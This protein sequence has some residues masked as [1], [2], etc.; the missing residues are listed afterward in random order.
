MIGTRITEIIQQNLH[1]MGKRVT[2]HI[3]S[4]FNNKIK[5]YLTIVK[6]IQWLI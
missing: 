6:I 3:K 2:S 1:F 4:L 5:I